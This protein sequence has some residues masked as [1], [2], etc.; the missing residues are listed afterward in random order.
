MPASGKVLEDSIRLSR[1]RRIKLTLYAVQAVM[2]VALAF[3]VVFVMGNA[4]I[5]PQLYLPLD[6]FIVVVVLL[7]LIICLESFFFRILEIRFARSSSARH[8]MAKNS[9]KR[10]IF[11]AIVAGVFAVILGVPSALAGLESN[12]SPRILVTSGIDP[13]SFYS[14]DALAL[15]HVRE[16]TV[17]ATKTVQIYL[18][19]EDTYQDYQTNMSA[20]YAYRINKVDYVVQSGVELVID[21]PEAEFTKYR[22]ILNNIENPGTG[23]TA[24]I[25]RKA[26]TTFTGAG[27]LLM[28]SFVV[29]NGAWAA[30]LMPIE[31]KYSA[32]S[33]YT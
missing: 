6:S 16:V 29:A 11:I 1:I 13:P 10:A 28:L 17:T 26:S 27:S 4:T 19:D 5:R 33:I 24:L 2:L 18:L 8:L 31:R 12:A 23:A 20:L 22:L 14:T 9:I 30:Y 25:E 32:G 3:L 15:S 21:V 7:L